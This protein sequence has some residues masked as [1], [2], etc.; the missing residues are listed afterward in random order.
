M[1]P[2]A[3]SPV[4]DTSAT[5]VICLESS[6]EGEADLLR[7]G[8]GCRGLAGYYH[9]ACAVQAAQAKED[10][11]THC[12]TCTQMW[13]GKLLE[14]LSRANCSLLKDKELTG[15]ES[16]PER[17]L[18]ACELTA[19]LTR[20]GK[21]TEALALG[22]QTLA[23]ARKLNKAVASKLRDDGDNQFTLTSMARLAGVHAAMGNPAAAMPLQKQ[24][25]AGRRR[26]LGAEH[27]GT[28]TAMSALAALHTELYEYDVA[29]PLFEEALR[30]KRKL[31]GE[32]SLPV[33]RCENNMGQI[34]A[35]R[36][37]QTVAKKIYTS[38]VERC[39][40]L[41]GS[42]HPETLQALG[43]LGHITC[44]TGE[45][46]EGLSKLEQCVSGLTAVYGSRSHPSAMHYADTMD[47]YRNERDTQQDNAFVRKLLANAEKPVSALIV[48][49][50]SRPEL[51]GISVCVLHYVYS[52]KRYTV[53]I[54]H[55]AEKPDKE[56]EMKQEK[57]D[58]N[59]ENLEDSDDK[60]TVLL[61]LKPANLILKEGT[62]VLMCNLTAV[63]ELNGRP[64]MISGFDSDKNRYI[65]RVRDEKNPKRVRQD[66]VDV[67]F[68]GQLA[69]R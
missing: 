57:E 6:G 2:V 24:V 26:L 54:Q 63:P 56:H 10:Q 43:N 37:D 18:A 48:G 65:V 41:L 64:G 13:S 52:K 51:N 28:V 46:D 66:C 17:I 22:K 67:A 38:V 59:K 68:A 69:A 5:C 36:G 33:M 29:L 15:G 35:E 61:N 42:E 8:C 55:Q 39:T 11:W 3:A 7:G 50:Q 47:A 58:A 49:L 44:Q 45:F 60:Q 1:Q 32:D 16:N 9:V 14:E 27:E 40:R 20:S 62:T 31:F 23:A 21:L 34:H 25:L 19:S 12:P 30:I 4:R 53:E